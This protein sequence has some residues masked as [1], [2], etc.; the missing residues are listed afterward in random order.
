MK[1]AF[2]VPGMDAEIMRRIEQLEA[3]IAHL[4][5]TVDQ[6]NG[7]M[8]EHTKTIERLKAQLQRAAQTLETI[9]MER[10]KSTNAKPPHYA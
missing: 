10:V 2:T 1:Q 8:V 3:H 7:V 6:L 5:H 4:E 9:E